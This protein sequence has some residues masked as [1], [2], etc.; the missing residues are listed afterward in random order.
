MLVSNSDY[1]AYEASYPRESMTRSYMEKVSYETGNSDYNIQS[2]RSLHL[3]FEL[4]QSVEDVP[5]VQ[6][7]PAR[8]LPT[9]RHLGDLE[10]NE[11]G[12]GN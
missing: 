2:A 5:V 7:P 12:V 3:V 11:G 9:A 8:G 6:L 10:E 4:L 1:H